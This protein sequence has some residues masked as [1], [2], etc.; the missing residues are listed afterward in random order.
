ML[1]KVTFSLLN[2]LKIHLLHNVERH[3][4]IKLVR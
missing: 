3:F 1:F 2:F 4:L